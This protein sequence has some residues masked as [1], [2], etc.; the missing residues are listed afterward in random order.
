M[1]ILAISDIHGCLHTFKALL[2]QINLS[3]ADQLFL[4]G[5]F[6]DRGPDSKG[7]IDHIW[8]LQEAGYA[9]TCLKGNHEELLLKGYRTGRDDSV[10]LKHGGKATLNSFS[11]A[12]ASYIPKPYIRWMD[13]LPLF[14][15]HQQYIFVHAGL[16]F[17]MPNPL[18]AKNSMLWIR[19]WHDAINYDW[20]KDRIV[21]HGHT[22][23]VKSEIEATFE[24]LDYLQYLDID[25]GCV[26]DYNG[27][28]HLCAVDLTNRELYFQKRW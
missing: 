12:A 18:D 1:R 20:L 25:A 23:T 2:K 24:R 21:I 14:V 27:F 4:V 5:D 7:V 15:E 11:V 28:G 16:N 17:D 26:F 3:K 13:N 10:W 6:V 9:I 19:G 22:P 8:E